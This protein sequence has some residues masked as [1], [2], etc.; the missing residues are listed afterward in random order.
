MS[1]ESTRLSKPLLDVEIVTIFPEIFE[2]ILRTSLVG[3]AVESGRIRVSMTN[4]RNFVEAHYKSVDDAPYGGGAGMIFKA[5]P[6]AA[7]I[8]SVEALRGPAY[9]I[10]LSPAGRLFEQGM[11][12]PLMQRGRLLFICGRYEGID[13]RIT[14]LY[15]DDVLSIG[16]Y[17]LAGGEL[18]AAVILECVARLVPGVLGSAASTEDE[19]FTNAR[20]EYPQWTRPPIFKGRT[21]PA[22]LCSGN[23]AEVDAWRRYQSFQ[24]TLQN[25]PD[26]FSKQPP[27]EAECQL[28]LRFF[29]EKGET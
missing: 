1:D 23:H 16:D 17:V 18:P 20:L 29:D 4:P 7:A 13:E 15:A 14:E 5:A 10:V 21:V 27:S 9:K 8:E 26:L 12:K 11:A 28:M 2:S 24:R 19:S 6:I 3:K 25:R 22:V